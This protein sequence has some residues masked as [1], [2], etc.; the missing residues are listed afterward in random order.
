L[1]NALLTQLK[2]WLNQSAPNIPFV[3]RLYRSLTGNSLTNLDVVALISAVPATILL[4]VITGQ[5]TPGV[6]LAAAGDLKAAAAS[7]VG[8]IFLGILNFVLSVFGALFDSWMF[9]WNGT[10]QSGPVTNLG[11]ALD[12][13]TDFMEWIVGMCVSFAWNEWSA[14]DWGYWG[15]QTFPLVWSFI[16]LVATIASPAAAIP[17]TGEVLIDIFWGQSRVIMSA[18]FSAEWPAIYFDAPKAPGLVL[19][20]NIFASL[21]SS[22][23]VV[24]YTFPAVGQSAAADLGAIGKLTFDAVSAILGFTSYVLTVVHPLSTLDEGTSGR[25]ALSSPLQFAL[26]MS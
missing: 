25:R 10:G 17:L 2:L 21:A 6:T 15:A 22:V 23:E 4:E 16:Q 12:L 14:K 13:V 20:G 11:T 19:A 1:I 5:K 18:V 7:E 8:H 24:Y 26:G 3:S 9:M